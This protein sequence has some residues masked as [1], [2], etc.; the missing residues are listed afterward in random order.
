M[1][2]TRPLR[3]LASGGRGAEVTNYL[4]TLVRPDFLRYNHEFPQLLPRNDLR[5][6]LSCSC[7]RCNIACVRVGEMSSREARLALFRGGAPDEIWIF[8]RGMHI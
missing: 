2:G 3:P 8:D 6:V 1:Q 5:L 4:T 7:E